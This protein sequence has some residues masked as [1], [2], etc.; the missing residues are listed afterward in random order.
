MRIGRNHPCP[1]GSGKKYKLC[2][3]NMD[4]VRAAGAGRAAGIAWLR[5]RRTEGKLGP[6]LGHHALEHYG[7]QS[8]AEAWDE[9]TLWEDV[10][11]DLDDPWLEFETAFQK[12]WVFNWVPDNADVSERY[13]WPDMPVAMHYVKHHAERVD[14]FT[15]RFIEEA[16][17]QPFSYFMVRDAK[18]GARMTIRDLLLEREFDVHERRAS[19]TLEKGSIIYTS[20][21]TLDGDSIMLGCAPYSFAPSYSGLFLDLREEMADDEAWGP[22]LLRRRDIELRGLYFDIREDLLDPRLPVMQNTDGDPLQLTKLYYELNCTPQEARDALAPLALDLVDQGTPKTDKDGQLV[23]T[24]FPWAKAGNASHAQWS[25]TTLGDIRINGARLTVE[26][27]SEERA[28]AFKQEMERRLGDRAEFRHAVVSSLEKMLED[29]ENNP[30]GPEAGRFAR[31]KRST[32]TLNDSPESRRL[33]K[34]AA[35]KH[36]SGWLDTSLPALKDETPRQATKTEK[37]RE[38]LE[39]LLWQFEQQKTGRPFDPDLNALRRQLGID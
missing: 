6:I 12:W 15:T 21:V 39:A 9:F 22:E 16:C 27:N 23:S 33:L 11:L 14:S 37:G 3:M 19:R 36:W 7:P 34:E 32:D 28:E 13:H 25:K 26:V 18:P 2:C 20:V 30:Q 24:A 4:K 10:P 8:M 5:M 1:C 31:T 35:A 38:R 29:L 17:S